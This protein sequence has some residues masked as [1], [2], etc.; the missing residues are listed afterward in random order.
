MKKLIILFSIII[1]LTGIYYLSSPSPTLPNLD[2][3]VRSDEPG[4]TWQHPDQTAYYTNR[5]D[6]LGILGELQKKF[7]LPQFSF[8]SYR[9]NYRPEEVGEFVRDQLRS[10][11]LEEV[12]HPLRESLFINVWEPTKSPF[13]IP[14]DQASQ[15]M[16]FLKIYYPVKV[17]LRP[18]YSS[19]WGRVMVWTL[20]FP[21]SYAVYL[22]LKKSLHEKQT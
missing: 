8:A 21:G 20:I 1:Y 17:T 9:L 22:S 16:Y 13:V 15:R 4:D 19:T 18:V 10:Y 5:N 7:G 2:Q 6:R 3:A 11:Y 12:I 14:E